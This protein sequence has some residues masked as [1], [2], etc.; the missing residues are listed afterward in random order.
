MAGGDFD[1][2][3]AVVT[4]GAQGIGFAISRL[5][6]ERGATVCLVDLDQARMDEAVGKRDP[7]LASHAV[8]EE[9]ELVDDLER[10]FRKS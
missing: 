6:S 10:Y 7:T 1:G 9:L 5:L 3:V 4:G 2:Q 8:K